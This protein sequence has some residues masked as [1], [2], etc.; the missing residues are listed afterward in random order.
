MDEGV[1][2]LF[3]TPRAGAGI[4]SSLGT[5]VA[6]S[7][8]EQCDRRLV[9][10][11]VSSGFGDFPELIVDRLDKIRGVDDLAQLGWVVQKGDELGPGTFP[12]LHS[13]IMG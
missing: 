8:I 11:K 6:D 3:P 9:S 12:V 1:Q 4:P 13:Q 5:D 2:G 7:Q 10:R